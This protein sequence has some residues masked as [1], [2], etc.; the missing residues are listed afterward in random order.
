[1]EHKTK[2]LGKL[3]LILTLIMFVSACDV[4]IGGGAGEYDSQIAALQTENVRLSTQVAEMEDIYSYQA[5]RIG[6]NSQVISYLA[7]RMP[8]TQLP[9][10]GYPTLTP[11]LPQPWGGGMVMFE[12]GMCCAGGTTGE[13]IQLRASF[14]A[15]SPF[16]E[17]V[18]MRVRL[19]I[20]DA[21]EED[22]GEA[23]W[24]PFAG[25][26]D[27]PWMVSTN[28]VGVWIF[29]Q[30]RDDQGNVSPIYSDDISVEGMPV[31]PSSTP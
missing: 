5:T 4:T 1:M 20:Y 29:V 24:E 22:M 18:E 9:T 2:V 23:E 27:Y 26:K 15:G 8:Y 25:E 19:G 17:V 10:Q 21:T 14:N 11:Y 16:G 12:D 28:W 31:Q 13:E 7:T 6:S 3:G 30:F